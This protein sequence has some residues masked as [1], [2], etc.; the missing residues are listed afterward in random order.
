MSS[1]LGRP[2][3][4]VVDGVQVNILYMPAEERLPPACT[5]MRENPEGLLGWCLDCMARQP[6]TAAPT[7][8][9]VDPDG[10]EGLL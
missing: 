2:K 7:F 6:L 1:N 4:E 10:V 8:Q 5:N 9:H 3:V